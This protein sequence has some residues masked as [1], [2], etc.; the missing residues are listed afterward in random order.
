MW[1]WAGSGARSGPSKRS[2]QR[3]RSCVNGPSA[4]PLALVE[5]LRR[6]LGPSKR[7]ELLAA[8]EVGVAGDDLRLLGDLLLADAHGAAFLRALVEM[9]L[10]AC[11][12]LVGRANRVRQQR[13]S[14][15][16]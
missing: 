16:L 13:G 1:Y 6:G 5:R 10:E 8:E 9:P 7:L 3:D 11:L 2:N 15:S 14:L 12:V 4:A